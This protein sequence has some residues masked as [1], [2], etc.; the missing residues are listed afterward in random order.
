MKPAGWKLVVLA[1]AMLSATVA[2]AADNLPDRI[3]PRYF[4]NLKWRNIGPN[5][6]GRSIAAAGSSTRPFEYYFGATGGGLWKTTDGGVTWS[7]VTDGQLGSSSVGAVAVSESNPDIVYIG[8]GEVELRG[9]VLQGDGVY[10]SSDGGKTWLHMGLRETQA[11][12]RVRIHP[13]NPDVVYVAALGHPYGNNAERGV[14]RTRDGG[15]TWKRVLFRSDHAGAVDLVMDVNNPDTLYATTWEVYRKPWMLWSGGEGSG[16][17][18]TSDGG[19]TWT[20]L[21][22][23]PGLPKGTLGRINITVSPADPNRLWAMVEAADGG[24]FWSDDAGATWNRGSND[25]ELWQRAFFFGRV[26][27]DPKDRNTVYVLNVYPHRST[28]GGK[29]FVQM[30][31]THADQHDLWIDPRNPQRM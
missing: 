23:N 16:I 9:N 19:D 10:K 3:D 29:T 14:Y 26:Q 2:W 22:R 8:M 11:I 6:G 4:T 20:E 15:R 18:K 13:K 24:I 27:A 7:P 30:K 1:A 31:P 25:R 17:F 5:R 12:G 21:T 28:D